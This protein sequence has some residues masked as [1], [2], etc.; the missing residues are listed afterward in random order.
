MQHVK[1]IEIIID[2]PEV[3][4][5]LT[6]LRAEGVSGYTVFNSV[7]GAGDR[8]ERRNDEPDGGSGNSCILTATPPEKAAA[9]VEA[10]R[11]ILKRRGGI[12]LVSDASWVVH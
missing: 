4:A 10:V 1:R 3:P 8:G 6:I 9:L 7:T 12:C 5:L 2:T 11:P